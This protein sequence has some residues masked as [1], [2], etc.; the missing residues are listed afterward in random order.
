LAGGRVAAMVA[1]Q[2]NKDGT[3]AELRHDHESPL[4][5]R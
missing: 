4:K 1:A 2:G 5:G 3:A